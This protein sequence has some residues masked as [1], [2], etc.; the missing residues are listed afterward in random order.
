MVL[1]TIILINI[2]EFL[3]RINMR[4]WLLLLFL[5]SLQ[6]NAQTGIGT[7]TPDASAKLDVYATN[8]G[9][10]PPR[11]TLT[12]TNVANPVSSPATGLLVYNTNTAGTAPYNVAPGYYYWGGSA[13]VRLIGPSDNSNSVTGIVPVVNGGTGVT[14]A[15]GSGSTVLSN[16]PTLELLTISSGASQ[17]PSSIFVNPTTFATSK[18]AALWLGD[19]GLLQDYEGNGQKNFSITQNFSG[20]YPTRF[21]IGTDGNVGIGTSS[22][23]FSPYSQLTVKSTT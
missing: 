16:N 23:I 7:T 20:S 14:T 19:W 18:R 1:G 17:F 21:F 4:K 12:A 3:K 22:P 5:I 13:W 6:S 15:T 11:I 10:L 8:K 2:F 9:F